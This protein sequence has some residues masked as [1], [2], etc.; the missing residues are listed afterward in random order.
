MYDTGVG[1]RCMVKQDL[2]FAIPVS[3]VLK[4]Y[5]QKQDKSMRG[6]IK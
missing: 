1:Q 3:K 4:N 5:Q 6:Q 2:E